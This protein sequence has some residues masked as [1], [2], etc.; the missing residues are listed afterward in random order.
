MPTQTLLSQKQLEVNALCRRVGAR[1]LDAF[2][3]VVR[4]DFDPLHSDL[5]F[6]VE[7]ENALPLDYAEAYFA[8]KEG[9]EAL[10]GRSVDL[11]TPNSLA[12]PY[13]RQRVAGERKSVYAS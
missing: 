2:G 7:F 1:K 4:A 9:L 13:L 8:L 11:L 3:S 5:D 10:F 6:L 12:N